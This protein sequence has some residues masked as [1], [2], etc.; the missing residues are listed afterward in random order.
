M[1]LI[2]KET[3]KFE[4]GELINKW[5]HN[6]MIRS[7]KNILTA[8]TGPTGS[9]KSYQDLRKAE[10][11]YKF[12]FNKPFP[13][14]NICFSVSEVMKR[15][16]SKELKKGEIII[17]EEA[18][19]NLGSLDFQNKVSKL[20]TYVLQTF[21][22]MNIGLFFNLPYLSMLNKQ[23]RLL[24]HVQFITMGI[25]ANTGVS[26]CKAY[27]RQVNQDSGKVYTKHL[28]TRINGCVVPVKRF[29]FNLP[30]PELR[31]TYENKK[32]KF[33]TDLTTDFSKQL[34]EIEKEAIRK[35]ARSNLTER[36]LQ[37]YELLCQGLKS[38]E[39]AEKLGV[40]DRAVYYFIQSIKKKGY[41]V[42]KD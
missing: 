21:R 5:I 38:S 20:F 11:W 3:N 26:R 37:V 29:E 23:A 9:G 4:E 35:Q 16:S 8:T 12:H 14:E 30:S 32:L 15:L 27:F 10:L 13:S 42:K 6:R 24:I 7:N 36:Q 34:D 28:R 17:F 18:G 39:I 31:R 19:A 41:E 1:G 25:D 33:V 40:S 22:S 2:K